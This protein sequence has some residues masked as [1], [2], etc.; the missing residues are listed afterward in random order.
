MF[1]DPGFL[2]A[3]NSDRAETC[4]SQVFN[5]P[6]SALVRPEFSTSKC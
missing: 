4:V 3:S 5:L 1:G 6:Y 2:D